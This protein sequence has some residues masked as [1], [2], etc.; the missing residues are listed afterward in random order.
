M[1]VYFSPFWSEIQQFRR[2]IMLI[3]LLSFTLGSIYF[4]LSL[5]LYT[6]STDIT[7]FNLYYNKTHFIFWHNMNPTPTL[8]LPPLPPPLK[9]IVMFLVFYVRIVLYNLLCNLFRPIYFIVLTFCQ[10]CIL[11]LLND[12]YLKILYFIGGKTITLLYIN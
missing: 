3:F 5:T 4:L 10:C 12:A 9:F 6:I 7:H 1:I 2:K 8:P 11:F